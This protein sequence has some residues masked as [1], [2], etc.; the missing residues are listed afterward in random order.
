MIQSIGR[1]FQQADHCHLPVA[2]DLVFSPWLLL[3]LVAVFAG[4]SGEK[5]LRISQLRQ[6]ISGRPRQRQL[7]YLRQVGGS[8]DGEGTETVR[9][10]PIS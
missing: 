4:V 10:K 5:S 9:P 2:R 7:D 1:L 6:R 3:L 8:K